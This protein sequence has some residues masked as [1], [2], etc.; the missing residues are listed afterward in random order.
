MKRAF[1]KFLVLMLGY[2]PIMS[3]EEPAEDFRSRANTTMGL[4][5]DHMIKREH[6]REG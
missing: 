6:T 2:L 1:W 5:F 4:D 3:P